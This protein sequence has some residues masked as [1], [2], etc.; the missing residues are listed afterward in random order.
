MITPK[1][2]HILPNLVSRSNAYAYSKD[3]SGRYTHVTPEICAIFGLTR[4]EVLGRRDHDF[5]EPGYA[6]R[7]E[8]SD[9]EVIA[10]G[11]PF[12]YEQH[13]STPD[14]Q[15]YDLWAIKSPC[16][17]NAGQVIG[18]SG[19]VI[20]VSDFK[21]QEQEL[22]AAR[23]QLT[24]TLQ[25]L[26][27]LVFELDSQGTYL[28]C[29]SS[30]T[31]R[32]ADTV[33]RMIGRTV[34]E[35]MPPEVAAR[36]MAVIEETLLKGYSAG[37][38]IHLQTLSGWRWFELSASLKQMGAN[39]APT[40]IM[41]SRDIDERH[42]LVEALEERESLLRA[43]V[44]NT[45]IEYWARDMSGRCI[46]ENAALVAHWGSLADKTAR[47]TGV[48]AEVIELWEANNRRAYAGEVVNAEV[49]Y[50]WKGEERHIL[51]IV[52]PIHKEGEIVGIVGLNQ[53][54]TERKQAEE[55][56]RSL[57]FYDPLTQLPNRR[58]MFDRLQQALVGSGRRSRQ[59]VLM[60]LDL[61]NFKILNDT[62]G[63]AQG[64]QLLKEVANRL[65]TGMREGDTAARLGGDEFVVILEDV[66]SVQGGA[67]QAEALGLQI[68]NRLS[69][70]YHL[71]SPVSGVDFL[72][73]CSCS[74]GITLFQGTD[75]SVEELLRQC[76][77]ALYQAKGA[78][79]NRVSFFDP[80][81]QAA[82]AARAELE[83]DLRRAVAAEQFQLHY[84][85]QVD[86]AGRLLGVEA[87]LRWQHPVRGLILPGC[88]ITLAEET[89]LILPIGD[90][91]LAAACQQLQH[92]QANPA[93]AGLTIAVNVSARQ[94]RAEDF[95]SKLQTLLKKTGIKPSG[96]K[97]EL[98]ESLLVD[99]TEAVI[100]IMTVLREMGIGFALDDFG[101]G[102]SS[103]AYLKRLPFDQLKIDQ[104]FVR[105]ILTD[106]N[107]AV[108]ARTILVLGESLGLQV[109][110][111]GVE[112]QGQLEFLHQHGCRIFQGY[113]YGRPE[114]LR[115]LEID[116]PVPLGEAL[117]AAA[118]HGLP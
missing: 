56:I 80:E 12:W 86:V 116:W 55:Q 91:V 109:I 118:H 95:V 25:A 10:T 3:L 85:V 83:A 97:L 57:A 18:L 26:P 9:R 77:T 112:D 21:R 14:G 17:D 78:G 29:Y 37:T 51:N 113:L 50:H 96:L 94:F 35:V 106:P 93:T 33:E 31:L 104:S 101:I 69:Q 20:N 73:H 107:D 67:L 64:D 46:M 103:L 11:R 28:S 13:F 1:K 99:N 22:I 74:I 39:E 58:L 4:T 47:A 76:D 115:T 30:H 32:L 70:P 41:V 63:H 7:I 81:M 90:W 61:D 110:A 16:F 82:V 84:Q 68:C 62:Q 98:T 111:E 38:Q 40:I 79:R 24:A 34:S 27:D 66:D 15:R 5:L 59:G 42:R 114:E 75:V 105:D 60:L 48:P 53:D 19:I 45:P 87:L 108:I 23:N 89:G 44:D 8:Q 72:Y 100:R 2:K 49:S 6:E 92:W 102:Y 54:I 88:F 43:V 117:L 71:P 65:R 52:A 36:V